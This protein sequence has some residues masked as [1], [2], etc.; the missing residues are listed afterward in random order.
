MILDLFLT[1]FTC[2][3]ASAIYS[4]N[5]HNFNAA[6]LLKKQNICALD[7]FKQKQECDYL[8]EDFV[9]K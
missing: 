5:F 7:E 9:H 4:E 6:D 1:L 8:Q 3:R 2:K